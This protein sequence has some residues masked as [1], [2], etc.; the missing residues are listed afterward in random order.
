[1]LIDILK[2]V[3]Y[4][5]VLRIFT[6]LSWHWIVCIFKCSYI[7]LDFCIFVMFFL[8]LLKIVLTG[9]YLLE[10]SV[11]L[12]ILGECNLPQNHQVL[13]M[14]FLE[15]TCWVAFITKVTARNTCLHF[16]IYVLCHILYERSCFLCH[17]VTYLAY[18]ECA[19]QETGMDIN[20]YDT[21]NK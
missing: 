20:R 17:V 2:F 6:K 12:C 16:D 5:K 9:S 1:M 8:K 11:A 7:F 10:Y 4:L 13:V 21:E 19:T 15:F 3:R 14:W 18:G